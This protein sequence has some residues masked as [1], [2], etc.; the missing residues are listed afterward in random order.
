MLTQKARAGE[1]P[2]QAV[3]DVSALSVFF[4]PR[5]V[6]VVGASSD[7]KKPGSGPRDRHLSGAERRTLVGAAGFSHAAAHPARSGYN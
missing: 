5:S 6:A 1:E 2:E 3:Q 4:N 7:P